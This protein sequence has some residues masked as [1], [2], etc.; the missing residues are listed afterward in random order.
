MSCILESKTCRV[1]FGLS[2]RQGSQE[3]RGNRTPESDDWCSLFFE[4]VGAIQDPFMVQKVLPILLEN[5]L[6]NGKQEGNGFARAR[7]GLRD[8]VMS[9]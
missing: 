4:I 7:F 5:A 9:F 8:A 2:K 6:E 1:R 3:N